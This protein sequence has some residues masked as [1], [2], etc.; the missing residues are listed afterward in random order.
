MGKAARV[1]YCNIFVP[2]F[3]EG[4]AY[5]STVRTLG[6]EKCR[7]YIASNLEWQTEAELRELFDKYGV[8]FVMF[9]ALDSVLPRRSVPVNHKNM[10]RY[11]RRYIKI[12]NSSKW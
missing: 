2:S 8:A 12:W 5:L 4:G 3:K 9:Q 6:A 11:I 1:F 10:G 7:G